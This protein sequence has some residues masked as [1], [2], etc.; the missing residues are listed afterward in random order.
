LAAQR[1]LESLHNAEAAAAETQQQAK[2][3]QATCML[4][5][6]AK[7]KSADRQQQQQ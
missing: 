6:C 3:G 1:T 2:G 7:I 5:L 4:A